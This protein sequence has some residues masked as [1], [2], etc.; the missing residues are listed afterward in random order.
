MAS[1]DSKIAGR[2][3]GSGIALV[4]EGAYKGI[5]KR[6]LVDILIPAQPL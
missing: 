1:A 5:E 6:V 2:M 3:N 4:W